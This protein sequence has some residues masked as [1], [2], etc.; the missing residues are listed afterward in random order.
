[1]GGF[2]K[3]RLL[4]LFLSF[5]LLGGCARAPAPWLGREPTVSLY[6]H[7]TGKKIN[8]K[9]EDYLLGVV[10][11]EMDTSWPS[12]ALAAQAILARTFT[13]KKIKEGGVKAHGTDAST[14]E[15][16]FQAYAPEK[17]NGQ[18]KEA[19]ALTRGKVAVYKGDY[20]NGWFHADAGGK[21]AATAFEGLAYRAEPAPYVK[22]VWDPGFRISP[23][24]NQA[25][26]AIFTPAEVRAATR[27]VTGQD[28]G[29]VKS[30]SVGEKGASGR[31]VT[32]QVNGTPVGGPALR[33]ALGSERLR[34][35]LINRCVCEGSR[36]VISGRG[37]GHGVGM[38]QWGAKS[39]AL[40]GEKPEEIVCYFFKGVQIVQV[41]P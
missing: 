40:S 6:L 22:S 36:V 4:A 3:L 17:I 28:P 2:V 23:P 10:A 8:I 27:E 20:I 37:Y 30:V 24:E 5:F 13:L 31:V 18:V 15:E 34:S 35:T 1:M 21:T 14:N 9:L 33:L 29:P 39:L 11:A 41:Y 7:K 26:T 16:E 12:N 25:W 38:S 32:F 19:V